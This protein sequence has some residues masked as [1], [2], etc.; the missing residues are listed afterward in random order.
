MTT[1]GIPVTV[2]AIELRAVSHF[3]GTHQVLLDMNL[4]TEPGDDRN[5]TATGPAHYRLVHP[6]R[7]QFRVIYYRIDA[8]SVIVCAGAV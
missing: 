8:S 7:E 1:I 5:V 6:L 3:Y 4:V 2:P